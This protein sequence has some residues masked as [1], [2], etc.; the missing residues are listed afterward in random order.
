M[1]LLKEIFVAPF[2]LMWD[3]PDLLLQV[4]WAQKQPFR[5]DNFTFV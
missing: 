1:D 2:E 3:L 5:P 4:L